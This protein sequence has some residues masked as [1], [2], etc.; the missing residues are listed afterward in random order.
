MT[1]NPKDAIVSNYFHN[2]MLNVHNFKGTL[3]QFAQYYMDD[4]GTLIYQ[5]LKLGK[6][7]YQVLLYLSYIWP[8]FPPRPGRLE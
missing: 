5:W 1:R 3:D 8:D 6:Q 7:H 2:K 4:E